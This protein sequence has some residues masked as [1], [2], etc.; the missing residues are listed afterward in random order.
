VIVGRAI[1]KLDREAFL[2]VEAALVLGQVKLGDPCFVKAQ[3]LGPK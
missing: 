1:R 3:L 2:L